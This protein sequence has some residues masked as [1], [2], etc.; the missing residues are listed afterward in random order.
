MGYGLAMMFRRIA[1][2]AAVAS[3]AG[4]DPRLVHAGGA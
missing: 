2:V 1:F 3:L 4:V